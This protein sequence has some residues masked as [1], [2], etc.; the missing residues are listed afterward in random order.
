MVE[1]SPENPVGE[2]NTVDF[3]CRDGVIKAFLNGVLVNEALCEAREGHIGF[4]SEGGAIDIRN[5]WIR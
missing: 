2:W 3:E 5:L 4:Q 1:E